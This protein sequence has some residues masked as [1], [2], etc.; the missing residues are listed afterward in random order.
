MPPPDKKVE[1]QEQNNDNSNTATLP[2]NHYM[3]EDELQVN[4]NYYFRL[5]VCLPFH[6]EVGR[7]LSKLSREAYASV[8]QVFLV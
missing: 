5:Q 4:L 7:K 6:P 8:C 3:H 2:Q 1:S